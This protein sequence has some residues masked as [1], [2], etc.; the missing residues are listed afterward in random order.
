MA[1]MGHNS[2]SQNAKKSKKEL[3]ITLWCMETEGLTK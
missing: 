1:I 2:N 3:F